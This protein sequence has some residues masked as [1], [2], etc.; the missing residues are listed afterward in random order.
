MKINE[1][2]SVIQGIS[3]RFLRSRDSIIRRQNIVGLFLTDF[4]NFKN[5]GLAQLIGVKQLL[6]PTLQMISSMSLDAFGRKMIIDC[7]IHKDII[8]MLPHD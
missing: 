5:G 7:Q 4:I 8:S 2:K 6:K 1:K 3:W